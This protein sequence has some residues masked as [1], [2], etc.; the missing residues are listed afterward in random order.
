MNYSQGKGRLYPAYSL[1]GS[2]GEDNTS[3]LRSRAYPQN[4]HQTNQSHHNHYNTSQHKQR[5][6]Y[7]QQQQQQQQHPLYHM[8]GS[9]AGLS[10]TPTS[11]NASDETLT[12]SDLITVA[13]DSALLVHNGC[14][15][16]SSAPR[17]PP[18][19]PP[20]NP[21]MSRLNGRLPGSHA[22]SDHERDPDLEPSC[23]VRT[24]SGNFYNIPKIPK[25]EYNNKNQSTGNSPIKVELQNNMDRVP[26]PY[27]HAPS[28]IPMRRQSIRCHFRK[29]IDWCSWKLIAIVVIMLSLCLTAALTYVAASNLVNWSYQG[30]KAC[31]VLVGENTDAKPSSSEANKTS[32]SSTSTTSQSGGKT[33]QP[34][35]SG[36][37]IS[38][39]DSMLLDGVVYSRKRREAFNEHALHQTVAL[40]PPRDPEEP[41]LIPTALEAE[42]SG[43][44]QRSVP[45]HDKFP[46]KVVHDSEHADGPGP[47][48]EAV[49]RSIEANEVTEESLVVNVS[50]TTTNYSHDHTT[51][52]TVADHLSSSSSVSVGSGRSSA[53]TSEFSRESPD[54]E[55]SATTSSW[56][57]EIFPVVDKDA[58]D[59]LEKSATREE[60]V[61]MKAPNS[62]LVRDDSAD[63]DRDTDNASMSES[64]DIGESGTEA[65]TS[66]SDAESAKLGADSSDYDRVVGGTIEND[67]NVSPV[68]YNG[69]I[70]VADT[71]VEAV[72]EVRSIELTEDQG[73]NVSNFNTSEQLVSVEMDR[74]KVDAS[75]V[76]SNVNDEETTFRALLSN[77]E[78]IKES[79]EHRIK[80]EGEHD[81]SKEEIISDENN[82][83]AVFTEDISKTINMT[84]KS[85]KSQTSDIVKETRELSQ[86]SSSSESEASFNIVNPPEQS[87]E[88]QKDYPL[89]IYSYGQDEIE[90]V[91]LH[92]K[93]QSI[94]K[95]KNPTKTSEILDN[96]VKMKVVSRESRQNKDDVRIIT[97]EESDDELLRKFKEKFHEAAVDA[98]EPVENSSL[99]RTNYNSPPTSTLHETVH[100]SSGNASPRFPSNTDHLS[101][102]PITQRVQIIEVPVYRDAHSGPSSSSSSSSPHRVLINVTIAAENPSAASSRPLYVL[103][104]SVPTEDGHSSGINID[105]AQVPPAASMKKIPAKDAESIS[106]VDTR[107]PP[108]PQPPASPPAPI[109]AGGECE[110]SCPCM[111]SSSDEWDNFS[112]IDDNLEQELES[113]NATML[114]DE[115]LES[116][117]KSADGREQDTESAVKDSA[118]INATIS[119]TEN[120][121]L[122]TMDD[123]AKNSESIDGSSTS[124]YEPEVSTDPWVCSGSTALPPEPTIL[125][126]EGA[127]TFPARSFPPD[128]TTF[129]QVSLGQKL[130]KEI[131]PYG[132]WNMQFYQSEAAYVRFD[133]SIPR[134]ASIG[135]YARRNALPTHTQY[136]LLEVLSGFKARTTRASHPSIKKEVTQYMEPGHWFLSLYND[137][138]DPHEVSFIAVIAEDMTHNCPNGCSGK[139]E[140]LLGHC[141]CNPGFGGE[142]CSES[143]CPVLCSQRGEYINGECQCNPGWKGKECSLR[144]DECEVPDCNGHGHC[145]NGKCNCVRGYKGKYCEEVDCPHPTCSGHG[146]CAEGTCICKKGWKGA[147]CSQM[148]KEA[149]QCLPDCSGHGNFDLETQTCLCEP[150]WSGDDCSKELCDLDCGPHGHCVDNACDCL[151]GWSGELC[152]LKQ[153]DPRCNEHG[154]CKNGTCLCVTGWNGKHCTMEGCP[155][156]CSGHGQC[157]VSNDAQWECQCY[158]GWD[159]KDCSV[160]LE[161]NCNDG[162]DNDKDGLIDCADPECCSN[163]ICRS[164][165]LCVSAPKPIDILLRKQPPAI[166]ASFF[167]RMK[168]L[169]DEGSLQNYA[170]QETFN[171]SMFWNHFN[172]SRSAVIRGRVVTHLGTGLMGVRVSTST[173]LEGFTLTRDDGWFDLLVNGGGAVTLQFG[174]SPFK[175][176]SHIVFVPWNEVVIIDKIV[177]ST[178]EEKPPVHVP[179][180]C[181]AHDYDLM[182]PVVLATWK[183]GFQ[184]ACPDK[185]AILAESQVIQESLQIPG[186][187]LNLVYHSSRAAG[188]LSTIQLQLT[189]EVIPATLNLIH[190]R[191]TIEG[192]LFEKT[193]E[194]DPVIKFTYAW[195]RLNVYRQRVYGVTTAM[196][197]VGYEYSD[198]KDIIWDVQTTKLSGHDMSISEV[199]GWNLD[200]HHRYNFHEGILQKGD[201]SNIYLKH[202]PRVILTTMGD[203]HQRPLDCYDCDGQASKQRLLAPVALATAADGS[204]FVGDFNLVRKILVDGTVRTVVRLNATRVSYRYHIALSPL[205]GVLYISDPESHQIIRV[206]DTNDYTDPDHNWETVVGSGERCLPGDEAHCGD[207]ALARDAKLAYPKGVAVSADNVLYFADGTNIR[208]VDRDGIIT[209]VIGNHMHKSHWKPIPCE[210]TLNVEEVHLRWPT[211][212]AINPLDNSL[213]MIDDHM[214]LQLAPDGRVK[215]VAGRPLHCASPS[216]SFD[217]ELATH[218]TLVMPQSVAFGPSGDLYIAESDS[219]RINRVRVIGTDGKIS[220]YAGAESKCNC[221][222]RGCDCFEADHYLAST[223]KFNTISAVAVSPDGVVHIGDQ[224]NYRIRSVTASIP[225]ASGAREYEIYAPDTQEIYVFNRFGQ[226]IATKNILTGET[227]Y[228]FT[229]NVNTSN[230]KLSTVTDAAGNKVFLLRDYSSQVNSI[231]NT[232]G[233]KCRL[234]MSR[235]K[236]LHELS[237]PDNYNVT[238]DYHGP[239]GLLKTK[240]DS[241]GRSYVYNYD[242]FGRLT[243]AVTPTGKVISLTFDLSLKGAIVKV[244]Q[245][246]RKPISMLIKGSSVVTK[247]GEAEQRTTVLADGSVGRVTPWAHTV[248]T[249]S[250]PYSILAEIEPLLGESYPVP[251]KQRTEIAGD[252]A[253]R[254]E[255]RYFLRKIQGNKNRGNSKAIAQVGRKLR[256]NGEILLSLEYDRETNTVAVFMDDRVE[257]LNVTYDRTARPVKWG[258][259]NGIFAGV[260]LEYD[261][262]SRLISWTWGD[263]SET[264]GFDRAGRLYEI[265]YSDGTSMVYAFKDMFSSLPLKVTTPRGSDYLLQ[266][267]EAGALQSLTTP[268]G[269]IHTFSLQTSLGFY[270]YQYYSP[271]NRHPYEILYNDDGQILAKVYPHQSG[272]VAY[273]YDH[274]GKLETTLAGLSSI[275]YTYQETT[276]LVRSIDI[277]EPNFEMRIEYKYHAGIVKDEKIKFGSKSGMDNAHYR[278]QYDGNARISGIEVDINGKQLPQLRLKYNQNLGV[279]EGVGDLRIYRNL[280]NRSVMQD[281]SKQFF[282]VTDYDEHG[283]VKTVLMNIRSFDVF[284]MELEYDNRN[285]IKMRKLTIGKESMEKKEWSRMEKI[286]YNA[287]GHV[288]EVADTENNW[289]YA[290]DENGNV[291]G[292]T[293]HNE[294]IVLGYD[295]GD[296][297]AQY[298]DVE[299][300]SYDGRGFVVIR[301]EHKYRYNS[302]GQLIH[303]S[304]HKKFQIWYFYDDRGRLVSMNDDRENITQFF[305]ANPKTPDL[306]THVHFPKLSKTFRFLYDSRDFLMTVETSEQR[307]YVATDQNGSPLALFDTNGNLIKEMRRTPF[308]KIIKDT[309]P[310]FYL[311][312]DFHGGLF[313]PNTKLIYLNKRLYDPTVGQ[314]MTPAWEQMANELTTPTDIFIYRFRNNDPINFKQNV[315]YMTDLASWLKLYGYDISTMLGS[316]YTKQMVYQPSAIVTSPQLTP[317]FGV[318]SGLQCIVNRVQEKFSDLGFVPKPLLKLEPKTRNLLPRVAHRRAVFGEGI[319]VSRVG[320]RALVSVVDGVNSVVQD[321]VTSVFNNSYFLPLHFSVHDQDVFYFVKDNAL[322]IRDD[323]EELHRLGGMFNVSTHETTEHGAGTWKELRLHNPDAAVVIKYG[324]DPEQER[325]RILKHAHKRAV[326]RAWEIEK[327]LVMAGF[328]GRGDWSK[329]EKDELMSRGTVDGYE[330]VDIHSVH[331]YPQLA[332]DPGNVAFTRDTK[333]KRRKSGNRRN[334]THRHDS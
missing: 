240:L 55:A 93:K 237:T 279:L 46:G 41:S 125:I 88:L 171:E 89:P 285:R 113:V 104:V 33:R 8:P 308:G 62:K 293:E 122:S 291:I 39:S 126:L 234:R 102:S 329:E 42:T 231:E 244:G 110:C 236:M 111:G 225:D 332:D 159:G 1:S 119:T 254:F 59:A 155:N 187:G 170:R 27:G 79:E 66:A 313:D 158:D 76:S 30:S 242:E 182:K 48:K 260:E 324:A 216:A 334:R 250:M 241:T 37:S 303:A 239:T 202:K 63:F 189:P 210:G 275:H 287:D 304:E 81:K 25:N 74:N 98:N 118:K 150:M 333:R 252:L 173:P 267:D 160:L 94:G 69:N 95:A 148:D 248:S 271:M 58:V 53:S 288:L 133:Y 127:R 5:A 156:S 85:I 257:L 3:S 21:A 253:N 107:L 272:K 128:G 186:T 10:D 86:E 2:E 142:D 311:P 180:A 322:K 212:L 268:R 65:T 154:Q 222:E 190:L 9:G 262:F 174:R 265:K 266:Y 134:G 184:G 138:G 61:V 327:Q 175:P 233:Q 201:G 50:A 26:L 112:A 307:F 284:R 40:P 7:Q 47:A 193:F 167:E 289:Q 13:R 261:R 60:H 153:C 6:V 320:G 331:R 23:L 309:N 109:W 206:R 306:I 323:M 211:E 77:D 91:D 121:Y 90:I 168:F 192:I 326:E 44:E 235:M 178:A 263:I 243:S 106:V 67:S 18:D 87:E 11:G 99:I 251:A 16:D 230:G 51:H 120:Y 36:G 280:F 116:G 213:H 22:A 32:T 132:Y 314:W 203:G 247:V 179:H 228:L 297:V 165:Q 219:Q 146:F 57:P 200:I 17:G 92:R 147:D 208:M 135:V 295:S 176:Q 209:T 318:M 181:A 246:N 73:S 205:D 245:N 258:P 238:F 321:V 194:A 101:N 302:R 141:Q 277:N 256:V 223:S 72:T 220:P 296:R 221:L 185:S 145:T 80:I 274:A 157:R 38:T 317:D 249:D 224:A 172:T 226:H 108:P 199:G 283:R 325:H 24:P 183:H 103:S 20:R 151:P 319:L 276:S 124:T 54:D 130:S 114:D 196:V 330:G 286:T 264:Y 282:T 149:L 35:S 281:S 140:C 273:V 161:Q 299:F 45:L 312:I 115:L 152:N 75:T 229:Y 117:E 15:L 197:K 191:I 298:G 259:R 12:D 227:V 49:D 84:T 31:T 136:D 195:N 129:A 204:I 166:T 301:G 270:K 215:V 292:V 188:Y 163:H 29:G 139:G 232:K 294:K 162:R 131:P 52:I 68:D 300:N 82:G 316:E 28:M 4:N 310:D 143:V 290:Y 144:H 64:S 14:L 198:C 43:F 328:Q 169:I 218:A 217:T 278:Y 207:G 96:N 19:V 71:I 255:W 269:H 56:L 177:M 164:S 70:D 305:Y 34:S 78:K 137:D 105:Q 123:L 97:R 100:D 214:V 83:S 315:E